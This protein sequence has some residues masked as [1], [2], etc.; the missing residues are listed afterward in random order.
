MSFEGRV[1]D[2]TN[3]PEKKALMRNS[4][5]TIHFFRCP[6]LSV[7]SSQRAFVVGSFIVYC[8]KDSRYIEMSI[9]GFG[10]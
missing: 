8:C 7:Y 10:K 9:N 3:T 2:S 1:G 4:I 6:L 5:H